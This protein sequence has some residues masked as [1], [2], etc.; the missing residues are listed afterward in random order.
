MVG[1]DDDL[2]VGEQDDLL[3]HRL[4]SQEVRISS[5]KLKAC[6]HCWPFLMSQADER[7]ALI[8]EL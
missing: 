2:F 8:A 3:G 6:S 4:S 5:N 1:W 7:Q